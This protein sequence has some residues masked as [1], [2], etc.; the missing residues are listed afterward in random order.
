MTSFSKLWF[1]HP[2]MWSWG[3]GY[4]SLP[5]KSVKRLNG[6][7]HGKGFT[8]CLAHSK[9]SINVSYHLMSSYY[10]PLLPVTGSYCWWSKLDSFP[11]RPEGGSLELCQA[12]GQW[13]FH[14]YCRRK[15]LVS[16]KWTWCLARRSYFHANFSSKIQFL[17]LPWW[18]SGLRIHLSMQ[19]TRVW[20][21]VGE[22]RSH[23]PYSN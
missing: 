8:W 18:S 5:S 22:L 3:R 14:T 17:G 4:H 1:S 23:T 12:T 10:V 16:G 13:H 9:C 20:F 6:K 15:E 21:L 7:K 2:S 19:G 11:L